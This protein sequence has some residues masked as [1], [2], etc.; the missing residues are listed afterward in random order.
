MGV[1]REQPEFDSRH[2]SPS[3]M[4]ALVSCGV[5][6]KLKYVD[7][8]PEEASGSAA[9]FGSVVHGA[10]EYWTPDRSQA[11]LPL[12][13]Q[14]WKDVIAEAQAPA[15]NVF[16]EEYKDLSIQA[17]RKE[18]SIREAWA[19]RGKVSKSP[20]MTKEWKE[21]S[22]ARDID[23]L[24]SKHAAKVNADSPWR[25]NEF[26][27]LPGLYDESLVLA[28][29]YEAK[30]KH[31][32]N[33]IFTEFGFEVPFRGFTLRGY[34]DVIEEVTDKKTGQRY[35]G[36][37]D[38]KTYAREAPEQKDWRQKCIYAVAVNYLIGEGQIVL[39]AEVAGL[40][41]LMGVDYVRMMERSF[42]RFG[43]ADFD[44]LERE[45]T[46]YAVMVDNGVYLPAEKNRNPD[47]C[48]FPSQCC[49]RSCQATG[50]SAESV[51]VE[52]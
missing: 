45:L 3:R 24:V 30:W 48:P 29:R 43:R 2:I 12:M 21:S 23:R 47:F 1:V 4:N 46:N 37:T 14:A 34:I 7:R 16:I 6:F 17:I 9:L 35:L 40:E 22:V 25:F 19:A 50:G 52:L 42:A 10:L 36:V 39:P 27:T 51:E 32:P 41:L 8:L 38:Y 28:K 13:R 26:G 11:L 33:S 31:L 49:L 20:R 18:H 15:L 5:A 44:R